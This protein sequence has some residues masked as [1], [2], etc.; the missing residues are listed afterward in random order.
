MPG[1]DVHRPS[2]LARAA[3]YRAT[4]ESDGLVLPVST[5]AN[6][7]ASDESERLGAVVGVRLVVVASWAVVAV[8]R[9]RHQK[10]RHFVRTSYLIPQLTG[11]FLYMFR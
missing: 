3:E 5:A 7:K 2:T 9:H 4:V 11:T 10:W 1:C 8:T 6:M